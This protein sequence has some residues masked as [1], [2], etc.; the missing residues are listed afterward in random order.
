M[1]I[2]EGGRP[3]SIDSAGS[4]AC[5]CVTQGGY[6]E[7]SQAARDVSIETGSCACYCGIYNYDS[8]GSSARNYLP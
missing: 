6:Y 1:I 4:C 5:G 8:P 2:V 3:G 7:G